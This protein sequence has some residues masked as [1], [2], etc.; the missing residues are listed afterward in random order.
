MCG[1]K[2]R[3][4]FGAG[5]ISNGILGNKPNARARTCKTRRHRLCKA[6]CP[7]APHTLPKSSCPQNF[8]KPAGKSCP[9]AAHSRRTHAQDRP[10]KRLAEAHSICQRTSEEGKVSTGS[11]IMRQ[12]TAYALSSCAV[13]SR[14]LKQTRARSSALNAKSNRSRNS[15]TSSTRASCFITSPPDKPGTRKS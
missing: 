15:K 2:T 6:A 1:P 3:A 11:P 9:A 13:R 14:C 5:A 12:I 7:F 8:Y 4:P 10:P